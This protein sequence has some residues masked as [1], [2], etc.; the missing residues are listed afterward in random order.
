[1]SYARRMEREAERQDADAYERDARLANAAAA[2]RCPIATALAQEAEMEAAF[3]FDERRNLLLVAATR[4]HQAVLE[5]R[6]FR[7]DGPEDALD[8]AQVIRFAREL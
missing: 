6:D 1:M 4:C 2:A 3:C 5:G 8:V 7:L